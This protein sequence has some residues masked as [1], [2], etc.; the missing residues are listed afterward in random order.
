MAASRALTEV[1]TLCDQ[2]VS[3]THLDVYKRQHRE[4]QSTRV[5]RRYELDRSELRSYSI[6]SRYL[7]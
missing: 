2:A 3:Y 7:I 6:P 5:A 4:D 1:E